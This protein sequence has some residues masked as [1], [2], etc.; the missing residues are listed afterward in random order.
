VTKVQEVKKRARG[1]VIEQIDRRTT[2]AGK[3][4]QTHVDNLHSMGSSL[5]GQGLDSTAKAVDY[6]ADRI[7]DVS[8]YLTRTD[9]DRIIHDLETLARDHAAVTGAVGL[10]LGLAAARLLKAS[11]SNRYRTYVAPNGTNYGT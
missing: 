9:G 5:R 8:T 10:L 2:E 3:T 4:L 11:A 1:I 6:A 7:G